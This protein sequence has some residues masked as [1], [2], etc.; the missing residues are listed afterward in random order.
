MNQ[1]YEK[2]PSRNETARNS[3]NTNGNTIVI[4]TNVNS[5]ENVVTTISRLEVNSEMVGETAPVS[6]SAR[7]VTPITSPTTTTVGL[8][9]TKSATSITAHI[10]TILEHTGSTTTTEKAP[11]GNETTIRN[12]MTTNGAKITT[13]GLITTRSRTSTTK[14]FTEGGSKIESENT[15][16]GNVGITTTTLGPTLDDVIATGSETTKLSSG[17]AWVYLGSETATL[18]LGLDRL[19]FATNFASEPS[20]AEDTTTDTTA[21]ATTTTEGVTIIRAGTIT[22]EG[23]GKST[24]YEF[25]PK[26]TDG[27]STESKTETLSSGLAQNLFETDFSSAPSSTEV[28]TSTAGTTTTIGGVTTTESGATVS[29]GYKFTLPLGFVDLFG[30]KK[31]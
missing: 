29:S 23:G 9:A 16:T 18:G 6:G 13:G 2:A 5:I 21:G 27:I 22:T 30:R 17:L 25:T 8:I 4:P 10:G 12:A 1:S 24:E 26:T 14:I 31:L 20:T 7:S 15:V 3:T 11:A 19:L 28:M